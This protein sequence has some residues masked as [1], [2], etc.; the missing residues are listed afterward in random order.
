MKFEGNIANPSGVNNH[1]LF[2][3][4]NDKIN[5]GAYGYGSAQ[6]VAELP[7]DASQMFGAGGFMPNADMSKLQTNQPYGMSTG[8]AP[9]T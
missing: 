1:D 9:N 3:N 7:N 2:E 5:S 4:E 6:N 8:I